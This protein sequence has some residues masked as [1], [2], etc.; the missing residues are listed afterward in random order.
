MKL[1][2][3]L[4]HC[5]AQRPQCRL[6]GTVNNS[7]CGSIHGALIQTSAFQR[8]LLWGPENC[9]CCVVITYRHKEFSSYNKSQRDALFLKFIFDKELYMFRVDL[10][11]II[12]SLITVHAAMGICHASY[13]D[14]L[15][16]RSGWSCVCSDETADDGQ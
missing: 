5:R 4:L 8:H 14:C 2:Q 7:L 6:N 13:V 9:V 15:L 12:G 1:F 3:W 10:L 11:P 16:A